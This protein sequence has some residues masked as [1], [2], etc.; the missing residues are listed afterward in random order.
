MIQ[1]I[2]YL[3]SKIILDLACCCAF[4]ITTIPTISLAGRCL[5]DHILPLWKGLCIDAILGL[6]PWVEKNS[7][8]LYWM[9]VVRLWANPRY[10][11]DGIIL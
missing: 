5:L 1:G 3:S 7:R 11:G 8:S 2:F 9:V 10:L 6:A 4:I